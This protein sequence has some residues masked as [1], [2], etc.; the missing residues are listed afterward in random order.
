MWAEYVSAGNVDTRIWPRTAAIAE[1]FWS[2]ATTRD[3]PDMYRRLEII[4]AEL[5]RLIVR[6]EG[7]LEVCKLLEQRGAT[8]A[9]IDEHRRELERVSRQLAALVGRNGIPAGLRAV[10]P[11]GGREEVQRNVVEAL[12]P[13]VEP[14]GAG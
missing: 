2:P 10:R 7:L 5:D 14:A 9:E 3:I 13:Q 6:F 1:R 4:D 11:A 12:R 8:E